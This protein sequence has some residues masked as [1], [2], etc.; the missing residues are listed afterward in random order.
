[1][2]L[3]N[4]T[5]I[6]K[7]YN[8]ITIENADKMGYSELLE[9]VKNELAKDGIEGESATIIAD[10]MVRFDEDVF[11]KDVFGKDDQYF[12]SSSENA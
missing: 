4:K 12:T 10:L 6:M 5:N 11:E 3:I 9:A 8:N 2:Y 1:L 7:T